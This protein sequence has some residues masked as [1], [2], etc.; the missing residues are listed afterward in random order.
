MCAPFNVKLD[1]ENVVLN[2]K[3]DT[4]HLVTFLQLEEFHRKFIL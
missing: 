4:I 3:R 2:E 1:N